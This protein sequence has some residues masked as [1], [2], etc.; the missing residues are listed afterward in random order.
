MDAQERILKPINHEEPD[1]VPAFESAF[2]NNTIMK[3]YGIDPT[4]A[5]GYKKVYQFSCK[6]GLDLV[7]SHVILLP[8]K[9]LKRNQGF[10]D[11]NGRRMRF[12]LYKDGTRMMAY[13]GGTFESFED[14]ES[15][16]QPDPNLPIR[17]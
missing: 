3:H 2:K 4:E 11:E 1:H 10:V 16:E 7:L 6:V 14:Y 13:Q 9:Y 12:E 15:W 5:G 17:L 8:R